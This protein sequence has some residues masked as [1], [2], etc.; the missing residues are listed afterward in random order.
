MPEDENAQLPQGWVP[1]E[2]GGGLATY[3]HGRID[4]PF[5]GR[6]PNYMEG[7]RLVQVW[8]GEIFE[9]KDGDGNLLDAT[10]LENLTIWPLGENWDSYDNITAEFTGPGN[11]KEGFDKKSLFMKMVYRVAS[12]DQAVAAE[13][14]RRGSM[15]NA[16][17]WKGIEVVLEREHIVFGK[18]KAGEEIATD[19]LMPV[20]VSLAGVTGAAAQ[21]TQTVQATQGLVGEGQGQAAAGGVLDALGIDAGLRAKLKVASVQ[22]KG[23][24]NA[25][26]LAAIDIPGVVDNNDLITVVSD[27]SLWAE[28]TA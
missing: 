26:T 13:L 21:T 23:D 14:G 1:S 12:L 10:K 16:S 11:K 4:N 2:G 8:E 27:G 18:N 25:F 22:A 28:L 3:L 6:N 24:A 15:L 20:K 17:V 9:A 5:F 7:K 19:H